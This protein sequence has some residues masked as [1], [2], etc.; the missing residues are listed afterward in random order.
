MTQH[1]F[2][3]SAMIADDEMLARRLVSEFL[4][5]HP[6]IELIAEVD[7]GQDA[8]NT[9]LERQPDLVFLDIQMPELTGLEVLQISGRQSGVI[10]TTAYDRFAL[11]AFD[12]HAVDYLLKPFSQQRFDEALGKAR[13]LLQE[14]QP[15]SPLTGLLAQ[16]NRQLQRLLIRERNH[17]HVLPVEQI[18]YV[19]AE[20]DYLTIYAGQR[21]W[22]KTQSLSE[23][24]SQLD[25]SQFVRVHRSYLIRL[26]ALDCLEKAGKDSQLAV[27]HSG[28]KIPVSRSGLER[29]KAAQA[30]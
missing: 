14:P 4:R 1:P 23:L 15:A 7:N 3:L 9:I 30:A 11:Q 17:T 6:D 24:E 13:K 25:A 16:Q 2:K 8:V 26:A 27:L 12:L 20:D 5:K 10:F 22:M 18:D 29:L 19:A 21:S 28:A